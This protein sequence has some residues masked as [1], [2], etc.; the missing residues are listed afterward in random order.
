[1]LRIVGQGSFGIVRLCTSIIDKKNYAIKSIP[2][3][4]RKI[5]AAK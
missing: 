1:M 2:L 5:D 4:D 3:S